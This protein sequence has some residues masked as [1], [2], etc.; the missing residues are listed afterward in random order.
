MPRVE[1][2]IASGRRFDFVL[3]T[4]ACVMVIAVYALLAGS[5]DAE[6]SG[7]LASDAYY[8]RLVDGL[9]RGELSLVQEVPAGLAAL[10]NPYD[11]VAN[12]QYIGVMYAGNQIHEELTYYHGKLYLYF[13]VVP[14]VVLFLPYH[15]LTGAYLSHQLGCTI[16]ASLGFLA[17]TVLLW[18]IRARCFP[19]V[20]AGSMA[21]GFLGLGLATVM[22]IVF[23]RPDLWEVPITSAYAFTMFS[24]LCL[25]FILERE[26]GRWRWVLGLSIC[27]GLAIGSRPSS[28]M[29]AGLLLVPLTL[30]A[31]SFRSRPVGER[32][33][34]SREIL[35]ALI[36]IGLIGAGL[37]WYNFMRF[38]D[39][40]EFGQRYQ[41]KSDGVGYD[42][43]FS[44][45]Y[46][47]HHFRI[48]FL[49]PWSWGSD[50]PFVQPPAIPPMPGDTVAVDSFVALIP[51]VPFLLLAAFV[52]FTLPAESTARRTLVWLTT[53]LLGLAVCASMLFCFF[54]G[55]C[56]RYDIDFM[57]GWAVLA[58][59][60]LLGLEAKVREAV[61]P[62]LA[63]R[64]LWGALLIYSLTF[65]L[66]A[67][68]ETRG[69]MEYLQGVIEFYRLK[70]P[71]A[72]AHLKR[73][74]WMRP[75]H[76][77]G[78]NMLAS[79]Y[80]NERNLPAALA[81]YEVALRL[82]PASLLVRRNYAICLLTAGRLTEAERE[83]RRVIAVD[84]QNKDTNTI[85]ERIHADMAG[86]PK[87]STP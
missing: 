81:E 33:P 26:T 75:A 83:I 42:G 8:N 76:V 70:I 71:E 86:R 41:L 10:P 24:L 73:G 2:L 66:L 13:G 87:P 43:N 68:V 37:M 27:A 28:F 78:H 39:V 80:Y 9:Q 29:V 48:Y 16:L 51:S 52:P 82:D 57:P 18:K 64:A 3:T 85:L 79:V 55:V 67:T 21:L 30:A 15:W 34:A 60:G 40:L 31:Q 11:P 65:T 14:A 46:L 74:I 6:D 50:F 25:W 56:V 59:I 17:G 69:R 36:P 84:P 23:A 45:K 53:T 63:L 44:T 1:Q 58:G 20:D 7:A 4:L 35:A 61:W 32:G 49:K 12:K 5:T 62:K 22:P 72:T 38:G 19:E 54:Y 47:F 77:H